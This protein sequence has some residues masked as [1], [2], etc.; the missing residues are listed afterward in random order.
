MTDTNVRGDLLAAVFDQFTQ[1]EA[2]VEQLIAM[3]VDTSRISV[4]CS[5]PQPEID[6][7]VDQVEGSVAERRLPAAVAGSSIGALLGGLTA[8]T[9]AVAT[10]GAAL[11]IAGPLLGSA[12]GGIGGGLVGLMTSRGLEAEASDFYDHAVRAGA[13][14]VSVEPSSDPSQPEASAV[15]NALTLHGGRFHTLEQTGM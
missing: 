4:I 15:R 5:E 9:G 11:M 8:L 13:T 7:E 1:A 12:A 6:A 3:G 14:L 2:A 10:G